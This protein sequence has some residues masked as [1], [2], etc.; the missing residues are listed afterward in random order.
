MPHKYN[1][2]RRHHIPKSPLQGDEL[3]GL[4]GWAAPARLAD[5]LVHGRGDRRV[6]GGAADHAGRTGALLGSRDRDI[7]DPED[8]VSP[9]AAADRGTGRLLARADG[10]GSAGAGSFDLEPTIQDAGGGASGGKR[11]GAPA[12]R[13]YRREAQ[14]AGRMA[15]REAWHPAP[16]GLAQAAPG[17]SMPRPARSSPRP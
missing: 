2:D 10:A 16:P 6:A 5:D 8:S 14:R 11:T 9:A 3:A 4:R 1:A 15:G 13:Q 17:L 7:A 12:G